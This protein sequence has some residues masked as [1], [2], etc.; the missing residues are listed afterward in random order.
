[1]SLSLFDDAKVNKFFKTK[2]ILTNL[3]YIFNGLKNENRIFLRIW[4]ILADF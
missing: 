1:L 4:P 3:K 2:N